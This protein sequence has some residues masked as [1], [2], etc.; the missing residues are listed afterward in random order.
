MGEYLLVGILYVDD[1]II[2]ISNVTQLKWLKSELK[3]EFEISD[4]GELHYCLKVEFERNGEARIITMNQ[5]SFI[6]EILKCFNMKECTPVKTLF[7]VNFRFLKFLDEEFMNVQ[8]EIKGVPY[9]AKVGSLMYAM[10]VTRADIAFAVS[11]VSQFMLKVG[12]P[13]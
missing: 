5:K 11:T 12:P 2:L 3:K 9:K 10:V 4:I 8:R 6:K 7:D 13:H 1:L